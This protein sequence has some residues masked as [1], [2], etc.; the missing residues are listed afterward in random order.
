[1]RMRRRSLKQFWIGVCDC[2]R[3]NEEVT[4]FFLCESDCERFGPVRHFIRAHKTLRARVRVCVYVCFIYARE[5]ASLVGAAAP[6]CHQWIIRLL[7]GQ[8]C[9]IA[10]LLCLLCSRCC[11]GCFS[12]AFGLL[13]NV[14]VC[15]CVCDRE[16]RWRWSGTPSAAWPDA[17]TTP[18]TPTLLCLQVNIL[19]HLQSLWPDFF[20]FF[21]PLSE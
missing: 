1:M 21:L 2:V 17:P 14:I 8:R 13:T 9:L 5:S 18:S 11:C 20:F 12:V 4:F 15:V 16:T 3:S 19:K 10:I 6:N 7:L